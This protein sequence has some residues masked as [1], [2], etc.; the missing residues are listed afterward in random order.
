L[1]EPRPIS[2]WVP[3]REESGGLAFVRPEPSSLGDHFADTPVL[4]PKRAEL[5]LRVVL[6]GESAAA[7]YLYAPAVTLAKLLAGTLDAAAPGPTEVIDLARTNETLLGLAETVEA[8]IQIQPDLLVLFAGN[9]W[10]LLETPELSAAAP[11][12]AARV[13]FAELLAQGLGRPV[14]EARRRIAERA[15]AALDRIAALARAIGVPVVI[16][17]PEVNLDDWE[18]LQPIAGLDAEATTRWH[19]LL[20]AGRAALGRG[21]APT[22]AL[23]ARAMLRLDGGLCPTGYRLL[24]RALQKLGRIDEAASAFRAEIDAAAYPLLA[25][26][27]APQA[28]SQTAEILDAAADRHGWLRVDLRALFSEISGSPLP[29]RR[30]FLDYCH[31]TSEG[32]RIAAAA[33]AAE[34]LPFLG[35]TVVPDQSWRQI[36]AQTGRLDI[37]PEVEATARLGAAIHGAHRLLPLGK[38]TGFLEPFLAEA[39]ALS[40]HAEGALADLIEARTAP[41]PAVATAAQRRNLESPCRLGLPHG[42]RWDY[43]DAEVLQATQS[44][45][46]QTNPSA[47]GELESLLLARAVGREWTELA[48]AP[49]IWE[50]LEQFFADLLDYEDLARRAFLRSPWPETG[51]ALIV[52][53]SEDLEIHAVLRC[54]EAT[55]EGAIVRVGYCGS[56]GAPIPWGKM[57]VGRSWSRAILRV[58][59][60]LLSRGLGRLILSW[61]PLGTGGES[62]MD[63]KQARLRLGL[64]A[65][66]HPVFGEV[67][68]LRVRTVPDGGAST[69]GPEEGLLPS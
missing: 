45:L 46:A 30:F 29:G 50:P 56:P 38:K 66:L 12:T 65:D 23:S 5:P 44:V 43:L 16:V 60:R 49:W 32:M 24:G 54:P 18:N 25:N 48:R 28:T 15:N 10:N 62:R 6:F 52:A 26:L 27:G 64:E 36:L 63:L 9:N 17:I 22:A 42:W 11:S 14:A 37:S 21:D 33:I 69:P 68:S 31:L 35:E 59:R 55:I 57:E 61:P 51:F 7:G 34:V 39:L 67:S 20:A 53:G 1:F 19:R 58:P 3:V 13:R 2:I 4:R 47:A 41:L 8:A 40:P